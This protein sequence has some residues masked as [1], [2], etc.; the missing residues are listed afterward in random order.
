MET[1]LI[2]YLIHERTYLTQ[3]SFADPLLQQKWG[4]ALSRP[5]GRDNAKQKS[6][7]EL[8]LF[9]NVYLCSYYIFPIAAC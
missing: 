1:K 8:T 4:K 7:P 9:N 3:G 6:Y 2:T 5:S